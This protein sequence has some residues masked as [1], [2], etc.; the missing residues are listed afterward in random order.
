MACPWSL[1]SIGTFL[2]ELE[3][4]WGGAYDSKVQGIGVSYSLSNQYA[5][6]TKTTID[7]QDSQFSD[8]TCFCT[9]ICQHGL[10]PLSLLLAKETEVETDH[11]GK[12]LH[13]I[14]RHLS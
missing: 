12:V 4:W 14:E 6:Q 7:Q 3:K 13:Q 2:A 8:L 11:R 1:L 5:R 9:C 10:N